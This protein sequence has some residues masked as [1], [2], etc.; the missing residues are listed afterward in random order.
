[1][2]C[3]G[4]MPVVPATGEAGTCLYCVVTCHCAVTSEYQAELTSESLENKMLE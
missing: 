2:G 4:H 1:M 3:Q